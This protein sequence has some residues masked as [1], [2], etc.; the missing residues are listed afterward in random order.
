MREKRERS[1]K[2]NYMIVTTSSAHQQHKGLQSMKKRG[3]SHVVK[4]TILG[5]LSNNDSDGYRGSPCFKI[6]RAYSISFNSSI[7]STIFVELNSE[8]LYRSPG[9]EKEIRCLVFTS[10]TKREIRH[11]HVVV[12]QWWQ[13][14]SLTHVQSCCFANLNLLL[15]WRSRWHRRHRCLSSLLLFKNNETAA[16]LASQTNP[17]GVP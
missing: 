4:A 10:S 16:M 5:S 9:K 15:F 2:I 8:I 13:K 14:K 6:Y 11:F 12:V 1:P 3:F 7:F 17:V